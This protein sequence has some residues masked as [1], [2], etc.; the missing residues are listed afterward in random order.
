MKFYSYVIPRDFGFA[1]N[2]YFDYCTLATCKP[3]IRN[4]AQIG[5]WIGAYGSA[6]ML[7]HEKLVMLMK[8]EEILTFDEYWADARFKAKQPVFNKGMIH[9]YG[10][11]IYHHIEGRWMQEPS[12]HSNMDGSINYT[13]LNRD[14]EIDKV[15]VASEYYYF[16]NNAIKIPE[17]F[18]ILIWNRRNHKVY[19]D[20]TL[21]LRFVE[22]IR[23]NYTIG[24]HGT[25]YSR[26]TGAFVHYGGEK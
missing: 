17:E 20:E 14:T 24:R 9:M 25:P 13:N 1:P 26:K 2:P 4:S 3:R 12:H 22:Y 21:I 16:G 7:I 18:E 23:C 10:D 8:V 5:D 15:L 6:R 11:N 19:D